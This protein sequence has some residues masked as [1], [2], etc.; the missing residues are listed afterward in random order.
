MSGAGAAAPPA[1]LNQV[2]PRLA[3][4]G[5]QLTCIR[6]GR[7]VRVPFRELAGPVAAFRALLARHGLRAGDRVGVLAANSYEFIALDLA[8]LASGLVVVPFDTAYPDDAP[9]LARDLGV[10]RVFTD[11]ERL[12]DAGA[13]V[14]RLE[15]PGP[16]EGGAPPAPPHAFGPDEAV[17]IKFT[18]GST[19]RPKAMAAR[20]MGIDASLWAVQEMFAHGPGDTVLVFLPLYLLQQRYWIYSAVLFGYD[21][22]VVPAHH[23][24]AALAMERPTVVMGVPE[25]YDRLMA[26]L[27]EELGDE[28]APGEVAAA[29]G[30]RVRYLWT[31]SAA[32]RRDTLEFFAR[33]GVPLFQGYGTN[34]TCIV[35]KNR[36]GH[37]RLGSA[38]RVLPH[39]EV[40]VEDDG[41]LLVRSRY[42]LADGYLLADA[43]DAGGTFLPGGVVATGDLGYLDGD[44]YLFITGR[45]KD[46]VVLPSG[47]KLHPSV[48]ED[49]IRAAPGVRNCMVYGVD[50]PCL[51]ALVDAPGL[52]DEAVD[53]A[54]AAANRGLPP[55]AHVR[56]ARRVP[57]G[58]TREN[59]LLT[60][61]YKLKRPEIARRFAAE[62][63]QLYQETGA[64]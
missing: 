24:A 49:R 22:V 31:G 27:R 30:G 63:L 18:S 9:G 58:F 60:S 44:G 56:A 64:R 10:K 41:H 52:D 20:R 51:V 54:V 62:L 15:V 37:D 3:G 46:L 21:L 1:L 4:A 34:E 29:L 57:E 6:G 7:R 48:I 43:D 42:P 28:P 12:L 26:A 23:G 38:G 50:R 5:N 47:R 13:G 39:K 11:E 36:A 19:K 33:H 53:A 55:D 32:M 16:A 61:Q 8:C 14:L 40:M 2:L 59:G 17:T 45:R 35:S 25:F